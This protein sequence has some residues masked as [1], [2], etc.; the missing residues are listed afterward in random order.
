MNPAQQIVV[1]ITGSSGLIAAQLQSPLATLSVDQAAHAV[2]ISASNSTGSTVL[3]VVDPTGATVDVPVRVAFNAGT[4]VPQATLKV[5]GSPIDPLWLARQADAL[6]ERLDLAQPGA[7]RTIGEP[8][9][10]PAAPPPPGV[11]ADYLFP[12]QIGGLPDDFDVQGTTAVHV[13]NVPAAPFAPTALLYDDDP[14][15]IAQDGVLFRAVVGAAAP[16]RLY[17]YHDVA[18]GNGSRL[19]IVLSSASGNPA[20]VQLVDA[21]AGPNQDVMTVGNAVTRSFLTMKPRNEGTIVD[22]AGGTPYV[23]RDRAL[24]D[25]QG[26]AGTVDVRVLSGGPVR[27]TVLAVSPGADPGALLESPVLPGDGHRRTGVFD[28]DD[29]GTH[30]LAYAAGGPDAKIVVGDRDPTLANA[31][32][33]ATGHDFGDYGVW[34]DL[35]FTLSNPSDAPAQVYLYFRPIGG[36]ARASFNVDGVPLDLG[37][38]RLPVPYQVAAYT[39]SARETRVAQLSTMTDGGSNY[40][41][42]IG[43]TVTAPQATAPPISSPDGCFPK[44]LEAPAPAGPPASP[45]PSPVPT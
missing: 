29:F 28:L 15:R 8:S 21:A 10:A 6:V 5:T 12:V 33:A 36:V 39:L 30:A 24:S 43:A 2:T 26:V 42:E 41:V 23:L 18:A 3:R 20:S 17:Y 27:V 4:I 9:A 44:P 45:T 34:Y 37:C 25:G 40:P 7:Q 1:T 35:A 13:T 31:D 16:A 14:E 19:V 32:P 38:V 11:S 22:L